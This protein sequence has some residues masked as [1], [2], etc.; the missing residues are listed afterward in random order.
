ML[1]AISGAQGQG[2]TTVL[3]EIEKK[4]YKVTQNKTSRSILSEWG[5]TLNEVNKY[6]PLTVKFQEEILRR[7]ND[8]NKWA[9]DSDEIVFCERSYADIF[10]YAL[11]V[12][13]P[14]NEHSAWLSEYYER[15]KELQ[16]KYTK[17]FYLSGRTYV[18]EDDGVRSINQYYTNAV[19]LLI[20]DNLVKFGNVI[21]VDTS[22]TDLRVNS[23]LETV[24][25]Y[26]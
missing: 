12:L 6:N 17:V 7:H 19:D 21:K 15:C 1:Y 8:F 9:I 18:P 24:H 11:F 22:H 14:F 5:Y 23:I 3:K 13:G 10:T 25:G 16:L 2:K 4:G 26:N 20:Y